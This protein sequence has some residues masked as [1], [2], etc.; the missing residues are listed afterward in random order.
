MYM[1]SGDVMVMSG[2]SRLRYHAVPRILVAPQGQTLVEVEGSSPASSLQADSVVEPLSQEDWMVCCRY[3]QSSRV[4]VTVRQVLAPGQDFPS[5]TPI[6]NGGQEGE[7]CDGAAGGEKRKRNSVETT[8]VKVLPPLGFTWLNRRKWRNIRNIPAKDGWERFQDTPT[9]EW[10][11]LITVNTRNT[12][13]INLHSDGPTT[14]NNK[15]LFR[16]ISQQTGCTGTS[17]NQWKELFDPLTSRDCVKSVSLHM[18]RNTN[19]WR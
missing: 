10:E 17:Y 18:H 1:H 19:K 8:D 3:I 15:T 12:P 11:I 9:G 13:W 2:Q 16:M 4:N 14:I 5:S 6:T 7:N